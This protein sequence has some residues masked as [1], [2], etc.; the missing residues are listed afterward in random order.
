MPAATQ[1]ARR[2]AKAR[3]DRAACRARCRS[4]SRR[5]PS[6]S[7]GGGEAGARRSPR[8]AQ[9]VGRWSAATTKG[10]SRFE[11]G[12]EPGEVVEPQRAL[13]AARE[14]P[15]D[16]LHA[17]P[18]HAQQHLALGAVHVDGKRSR[19]LSAQAS[20]GSMARS[21]M[22][23]CMPRRRSP[24]PRSRSSASASRPGRAGARAGA[25][26]PSPAARCS[27]RGSG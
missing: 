27:H 26:A 1:A 10:S 9:R 8:S 11:R 22:P 16:A 21:S 18:G 15:V 25:A 17:E 12:G 7:A 13:A 19:C 3:R 2:L 14:D 4:I 20:F 5:A 6:C 23:P 24:R